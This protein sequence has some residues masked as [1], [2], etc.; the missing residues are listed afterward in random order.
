VNNTGDLDFET[1]LN[2]AVTALPP[3]KP[4]FHPIRAEMKRLLD[5]IEA[6]AL[7]DPRDRASLAGF[8]RK[9]LRRIDELEPQKP[10]RPTR[11]PDRASA[12][13]KAER[14]AAWL[15]AFGQAQWRRQH[16][17][18][19]M[20]AAE[21]DKMIREARREAARTF[22]VPESKVSEDNIRRAL[23]SGRP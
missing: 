6:R 22:K 5:Y 18:E 2:L 1:V 13:E 3:S 14:N 12:V 10:G 11:K 15:V 20:P 8:V 16:H 9:L 19:R 17:R 7:D 4:S 23:K 21:T